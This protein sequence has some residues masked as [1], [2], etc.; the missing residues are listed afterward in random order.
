M[1]HETSVGI[2]VI[3][4]NLG[5]LLVPALR[6]A[7]RQSPLAIYVDS[8]STD[9][10]AKC[11]YE[12]GVAVIELDKSLTYTAGRARNE[13]AAYWLRQAPWLE[14]IQFVDGDCLLADQFITAGVQV[15]RAD[16]QIAIVCGQR[17]ERFPEASFYN[18]LAELGWW[19]VPGEI[20]Y[21]GGD[22]LVRARALVGVRG[23]DPRLIAGEEPELCL[24]LRRAGWKIWRIDADMTYHDIRMTRFSQWWWRSVRAGHAYAQG[25]WMHGRERERHHI[26]Q[27][28]ST[29]FW[30]AAVWLC[31]LGLAKHT[32]GKSLALLLGYPFLTA[33]IFRRARR[34]GWTAADAGWYALFCVLAKF[35]QLQGQLIFGLNRLR[36]RET[37]LIETAN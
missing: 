14:F 21:C 32:R 17:H 25:A 6:A 13:G 10:S 15:M 1:N 36:G 37:R 7:L 20:A 4:R 9:G 5:A 35:P 2:V 28:A 30:G 26:H 22:A 8:G 11:A 16:P 12:Q 31:A 24:R 29:W 34:R 23:Y 27:C 3:G 18:R 19:A 33:R